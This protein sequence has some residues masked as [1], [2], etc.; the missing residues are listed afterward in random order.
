MLAWIRGEHVSK[1]ILVGLVGTMFLMGCSGTDTDAAVPGKT[2]EAEAGPA[3]P[4]RTSSSE[5]DRSPGSESPFDLSVLGAEWDVDPKPFV[6]AE[7]TPSDCPTLEQLHADRRE[8]ITTQ[9]QYRVDG[10]LVLQFSGRAP[11][12]AAAAAFLQRHEELGIECPTVTQ[13]DGAV[14]NYM[15]ASSRTNQTSYT[16]QHKGFDVQHEIVTIRDEWIEEVTVFEDTEASRKVVGD[17]LDVLQRQA[18]G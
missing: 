3:A 14:S 13:E 6:A 16:V 1:L 9:R 7:L 5:G 15:P 17:L 11:T 10:V 12:A 8:W 4:D 2:T 18:L